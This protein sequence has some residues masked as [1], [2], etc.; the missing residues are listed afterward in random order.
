MDFFYSIVRSFTAGG[1]FMLPILFTGAL[2]AAITIERYVTLAKMGAG[3]RRTW[4]GVEPAIASGDFD[5]ARE[6][7]SKDDSPIARVLS[8]GLALQGAVRRRDD[9]EK[10]MQESMMEIVPRLEKRTHYLATLANVAT[11]LGLLGTV[12]GLIHAFA[13]VAT[14][15]PAEK[16]NLLSA[17]ISV[18]M[19]CT[20]FGLMTAVPLLF[21][22][23]WLQT[24]TTELI[25]SLEM[26]SV[27]FLNAITERQSAAAPA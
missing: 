2:A 11:L 22:H 23:A 12:S 24:R 5:K 26:A 18:A 27:K 8:M 3:N 17:S 6:L 19:N 4:S 14:V 25:D 10:A 15:N 1:V 13:A 7:T 16:A 9:I 20:A 21:I